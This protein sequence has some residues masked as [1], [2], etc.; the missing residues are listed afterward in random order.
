VFSISDTPFK[1]QAIVSGL[2]RLL[3]F[4]DLTDAQ[5]TVSIISWGTNVPDSRLA[6]LIAVL[7]EV[8]SAKLIVPFPVT[9]EVIVAVVHT[10]ALKPGDEPTELP[11]AGALL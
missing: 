5:R 6:R 2:Y 4:T 11:M 8:P 7:L 10:P 1:Q 3:S 9:A